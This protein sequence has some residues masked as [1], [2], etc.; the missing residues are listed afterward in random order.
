MVSCPKHVEA[1]AAVCVPNPAAYLAFLKEAFGAG[2]EE[3][4]VMRLASYIT[5]KGKK[6]PAPPSPE[7]TN[8]ALVFGQ[9]P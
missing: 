3:K 8:F 2:Y 4:D 6:T 7:L 1:R 9:S 5:T